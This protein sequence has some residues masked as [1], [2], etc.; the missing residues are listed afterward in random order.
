MTGFSG[1]SYSNW[2]VTP[3]GRTMSAVTSKVSPS[4]LM[5]MVPSCSFLYCE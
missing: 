2:N 3:S 1:P 4:L 5:E